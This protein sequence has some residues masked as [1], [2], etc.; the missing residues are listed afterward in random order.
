MQDVLQDRRRV[1]CISKHAGSCGCRGRKFILAA[2]T[3]TQLMRGCCVNAGAALCLSTSFKT[4]PSF[5]DMLWFQSVG[6]TASSQPPVVCRYTG[7]W[8]KIPFLCQHTSLLTG[9]G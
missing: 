8:W 7:C 1:S 2:M 5:L 3:C 4:L 9:R 6:Y